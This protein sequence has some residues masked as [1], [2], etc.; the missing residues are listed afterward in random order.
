M[1]RIVE[2]FSVNVNW[3][4]F[5][6]SFGIIL[7]FIVISFG[8]LFRKRV[9]RL[10]SGKLISQLVVLLIL[11]T[12]IIWFCQSLHTLFIK[13]DGTATGNWNSVLH[14]ID[15]GAI[16]ENKFKGTEFLLAF[17]TSFLG[18]VLMGGILISV[19]TNNYNQRVERF[20]KG[21]GNYSF[22][23]HLIIY[24]Y[25]HM[26]LPLIKDYLLES[27]DIVLVSEK[28]V[29]EIYRYIRSNLSPKEER[30]VYL[31]QGVRN[32]NEEIE[33]TYPHRAN[34]IVIL[35]EDKEEGRD[36]KNMDCFVKI[37]EFISKKHS[38]S[39]F[40]N[41][42]LKKVDCHIHFE[43]QQTYSIAKEY[44]LP[45][46][47][48]DVIN[49]T[50]FSFYD[51]WANKTLVQG[52]QIKERNLSLDYQS[53]NRESEKYVHLV[54]IGHNRMSHALAVE[55]G[56][57]AHYPNFIKGDKKTKI[58]I[59]DKMA[60]EHEMAFKN[61]YPGID[62][63]ED[64]TYEFRQDNIFSSESKEFLSNLI[65]DENCLPYIMV[66]FNSSEMSLSVGMNLPKELYDTE[67][68]III[69]QRH[70]HELHNQTFSN[71]YFFGTEGI[72]LDFKKMKLY[73]GYAA[74]YNN[75]YNEVFG[76]D[77]TWD[78]LPQDKKWANRYVIDA[79]PNFYRNSIQNCIL[80]DEIAELE[81]RRWCAERIFTGRVFD[82]VKDERLK[83]HPLLVPYK[84]LGIKM[85]Y[86]NRKLSEVYRKIDIP[87]MDIQL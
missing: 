87:K 74:E 78:E 61:V 77:T 30:R 43:E 5:Y 8:K 10:L 38:S 55:A 14:F 85:Q 75:V 82:P 1:E 69:R 48:K 45:E 72:A 52:L 2:F 32:I 12:G 79:I 60:E 35:G 51:L 42:L 41:K 70:T 9:D 27:G 54:L 50:P 73:E 67:I 22:K 46:K 66:C 15:P 11:S 16:Q 20:K 83:K 31:L 25:D 6:V 33:R 23:N 13:A 58:T 18:L 56:R 37:A 84:E 81:H 68:P 34:R 49:F 17:L 19:F 44:N 53:L 65:Q 3:L 26:S 64:I 47:Y 63:L 36:S 59:I 71:V 39:G 4:G 86:Q 76:Y 29:E 7:S 80:S 40:G 24:G 57:I 28:N 21:F 62:Q